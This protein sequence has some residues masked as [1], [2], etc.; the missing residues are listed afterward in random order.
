M[1]AKCPLEERQS[2]RCPEDAN[3]G[4]APSKEV[5][6]AGRYDLEFRVLDDHDPYYLR[7]IRIPTGILT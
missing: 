4:P 7:V 3:D 5:D 1:L 6:L 2:G